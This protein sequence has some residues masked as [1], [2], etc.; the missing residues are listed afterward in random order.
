MRLLLLA[1]SALV[2]LAQPHAAAAQHFDAAR[3]QDSLATMHDVGALRSLAEAEPRDD[4]E[5]LIAHG[6]A[7]LRLF[8]HSGND[9]DARRAER[10]FE[11]A[12]ELAPRSAWAHYGYG[13]ALARIPEPVIPPPPLH[14]PTGF[15]GDDVL[16]GA[17]G[18]DRRARARD[19]LLRALRLDPLHTRAAATLLHLGMERRD[20][21]AIR[22]AGTALAV[23]AQHG[24]ADADGLLALATAALAAGDMRQ[25]REA[26]ERALAHGAARA[27]PAARIRAIALMRTPGTEADGARAYFAGITRADSATLRLYRD[28]VRH[29]AEARELATFEVGS[30]E[31]QRA[32]LRDFWT[33][34]AALSGVSPD[35]R[36]AEHYRRLAVAQQRYAR[37]RWAGV[38]P[39]SALIWERDPTMPYDD[40]GLIYLRH[41]E[42]VEA[43]RSSRAGGD[44][45]ETWIYRAPDGGWQL[46]NFVLAQGADY[47]EYLLLY[48][49]PCDP[50]WL[51]D[52]A[53]YS[54]ALNDLIARCS[55][56]RR[57]WAGLEIRRY[58]RD[59][60]VT[61]SDR[62]SFERALPFAQQLYNFRAPDGRS[63][64]VAV[65]SV[66][67]TSL[68]RADVSFVVADTIFDRFGATDTTVAPAP[69]TERDDGR[70]EAAVAIT[71]TPVPYGVYRV[72]VRDPRDSARGGWAGGELRVRD[73][74]GPGHHMSDLMLGSPDVPRTLRRGT[75]RIALSSRDVFPGGRLNVYYEVYGV[76]AEARYATRIAVRKPGGGIGR[77]ISRLFGSDD[78][79]VLRFEEAAALDEDGVLR[80][81][82]EVSS[83][84]PAGDYEIEVSVRVG[85]R[86]V[87]QTRQFTVPDGT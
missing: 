19:A 8:A 73:L 77:A 70:R 45:S 82:R 75:A 22:A 66:E 12:R 29:I 35:A 4:A 41:G 32:W 56:A 86:E 13:A 9:D 81:T 33:M 68:A 5:A 25:A 85:R 36:I 10:S 58:V 39:K 28:D 87:A 50:D 79:V 24:A 59:A 27:G 26:A 40:R 51:I 30:L 46:F 78:P 2:V 60:L 44:R 76:P 69:G 61:D 23:A 83:G 1:G 55:G 37:Q 43:I 16:L 80:L 6:L 57:R 31:Q 3:L 72:F 14:A 48:D 64:I 52:R 54:D 49:V 74:T 34:R 15:L 38:P 67:D 53:Q 21:D 17:L 71:T 42:P 11:R 20:E 84:L 63:E 47:A 65:I 62:P 7:S 18:L